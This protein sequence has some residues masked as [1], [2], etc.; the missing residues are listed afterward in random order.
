MNRALIFLTTILFL[1]A[2]P[3]QAQKKQVQAKPPIQQLTAPQP[4]I[5]SVPAGKPEPAGTSN[6][7]WVSMIAGVAPIVTASVALFFGLLAWRF[8]ERSIRR[9]ARQ[10]HVRMLVDLD[11]LFIERPQLWMIYREDFKDLPLP[12]DSDQKTEAARRRALIYLLLNMFEVVFDFDRHLNWRNL[13]WR[14][15]SDKEYMDSWKLF[16]RDF[17]HR[18]PEAVEVMTGSKDF[19]SCSFVKFIQELMPTASQVKSAVVSTLGGT[20]S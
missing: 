4:E 6:A 11:K 18:S 3:L 13:N 14:T 1:A 10:D 5:A 7:S 2:I 20:Q 15:K 12:H 19:F 8:N 9:L 16:I 17:F